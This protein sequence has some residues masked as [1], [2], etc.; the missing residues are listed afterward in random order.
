MQKLKLNLDSLAIHNSNVL[1]LK[2]V[3]FSITKAMIK[4]IYT[5]S[6]DPEF[7]GYRG[8][9]LLLAAHKVS[10]GYCFKIHIHQS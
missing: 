7:F 4:F 9:D 2:D 6:L 5:G 8:I 1:D 3:S 10:S